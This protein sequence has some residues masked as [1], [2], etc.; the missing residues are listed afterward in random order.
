[1]TQGRRRFFLKTLGALSALGDARIALAR[2]TVPG[3]VPAPSSA[4]TAAAAETYSYL[5][6]AEV[7]FLE[8]ALARLIPAD[9]LGP[10]AKEAGVAVFI[11]RQ[12]DGDFGTMAREYRLG[13]W[14]DG[15][16]QQGYQSPL[17]PREIY[18]AGIA[19]IDGLCAS[20]HGRRFSELDPARQDEVLHG[21]EEG[22]LALEDA[23]ARLF[24][25]LL[26]QNTREGF[27]A[28]PVYGGNL[29]K[30]GWKLVGFPGVAAA[31]TEHV[32]RHGVPYRVEPVSIADLRS[33]RVGTDA[34]GHP[35]HD[36]EGGGK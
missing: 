5:S 3:P 33:G 18:R 1:M 11:D 26:W 14:A 24:F 25:G 36:P 28:D 20:R 31:Y 4:P 6:P 35:R 10:G 30:V 16:P 2:S 7:T 23:T 34:H 32:E 29:G 13:P 12:L 21:L 27:F 15:T 22:T 17:T 8:A 19:A 9:D